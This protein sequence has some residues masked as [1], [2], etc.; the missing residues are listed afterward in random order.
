MF[1]NVVNNAV[2]NTPSGG[3]VLVKSSL[4]ENKY[5]VTITDTGRGIAE[6]Q[7]NILF[8]RFKTRLETQGSG[9]G[10]GLAISKSIADFHGIDITVKSIIQK[11]TSFSFSFP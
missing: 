8:S 9:T 7:M 6:A 2:K 1:Y 3:D 5:V 11:G 4:I 10:I